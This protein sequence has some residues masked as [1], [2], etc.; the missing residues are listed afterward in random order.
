MASPT[1][2][3]FVRLDLGAV[4][5]IADVGV[6]VTISVPGGE[7]S[8]TLT[9][10]VPLAELAEQFFGGDIGLPQ[11]L[12]V[13]ELRI[14]TDT[15][16][17][18]SAY[19]F[20]LGLAGVWELTGGVTIDGLSLLLESAD[21]A[22]TVTVAG[23]FGVGVGE[24][25]VRAVREPGGGWSFGGAAAGITL[26]DLTSVLEDTFGAPGLPDVVAGLTLAQLSV[27]Y[28]TG[29]RQFV[30]TAGFE[31]P[32][33]GDE[34]PA[35]FDLGIEL[36][37]KQT[38][39]GFDKRL[40]AALRIPLPVDAGTSRAMDLTVT[41]G[42]AG[43]FSASWSEEGEEPISVLDMLAAAGVDTTGLRELVPDSVWPEMRRVVLGYDRAD[44]TFALVV[45][46]ARVSVL[47][48]ATPVEPSG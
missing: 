44:G 26:A 37:P 17:A 46:T 10:P 30:L 23:V 20:E 16:R 29:T 28:A 11:E 25:V 47:A 2:Q 13:S 45:A 18:S 42:D 21:G 7:L 19:E 32:L 15:A 35:R 14:W 40:S 9:E 48:A 41:L 34:N 24:V 1:A 22:R 3:G 38:A 27:E 5:T 39:T 36:T 31:L 43:A 33:G 12:T 8:G 4:L 6:A